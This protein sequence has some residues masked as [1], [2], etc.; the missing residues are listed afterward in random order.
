LFSFSAGR[1]F[2]TSIQSEDRSAAALLQAKVNLIVE[3]N[4]QEGIVDVDLAIVLD[5]A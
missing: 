2:F 3:D 5:E 4:T 1:N